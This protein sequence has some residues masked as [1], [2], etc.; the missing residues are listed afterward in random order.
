MNAR[1]P[2]PRAQ[3]AAARTVAEMSPSRRRF[4]TGAGVALSGSLAGCVDAVTGD[5]TFDARAATVQPS[6]LRATNYRRYRVRT[7][8][9]TR[10]VG[11]GPVHRTVRVNNVVAEYDQGVSVLGRRVQAAVFAVLSTPRVTVLG[12]TF[13]PV[14]DMTTDDLVATVQSRY[15][16]VEN[17]SAV[18]ETEATLLGQRTTLARY[19]ADARLAE[20]G[21]AVEVYLFVAAA[22]AAGPDFV[23]AIA[24]HPVAL[25]PREAR[26]RTLLDGA[27]HADA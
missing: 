14:G 16:G 27:T 21:L 4:L 12:R 6:T 25:G 15:E 8:A 20:S 1:T 2:D 3:A 10:R 9:V 11:V 23:L 17:V 13:N 26:V 18:D 5:L 19:T 24:A 7:D 22:V